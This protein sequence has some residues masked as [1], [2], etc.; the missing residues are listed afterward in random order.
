MSEL[1]N[2][3]IERYEIRERIG[4][5]GMA[6][7]YKAWDTKLERLVAIKLLHEHLA[8]DPAF[9]MRFEREAKVVAS[10]DHPNIVRIFDYNVVDRLG[11]PLCYMVM[12]Y[13]PGKT[14]RQ[15]M[16][17]TLAAGSGLP[18]PRIMRLI[19]HLADALDYA[20]ARGMAHRD[21]KPGNILINEAGAAILTDFGIARLPQST[22]L[23]EEG[24]STGTPAYMSPEQAAGEG[25]DT[26]SDLYSLGVIV[27][28][29]FAGQ[30]PF[31]DENSLSVMMRHISA[32]IPQLSA[33][34]GYSN[35][36][37]DFFIARALAKNPAER[38]QSA[39]AF[40]SAFHRVFRD[41]IPANELFATQDP[42][43]PQQPSPAPV[44][45]APA[46][47][48]TAV[49]PASAAQAARTQHISIIR[50]L[51]A[52]VRA[53]PRASTG[54]VIL[55]AALV[56]TLIISIVLASRAGSSPALTDAQE[57][58]ATR[59]VDGS[60]FRSR[61]DGADASDDLWPILQG[62][63]T[64]DI[65]D[66]IYRV[67]NADPESASSVI[68]GG[69]RYENVIIAL[70]GI[71][72][73][74]SSPDAALGLVFRYQDENNYNVLAVDTQGR[75]GLWRLQDGEWTELRCNCSEL[76]RAWTAS[77][78]IHPQGETN[79]LRVMISGSRLSVYVNQQRLETVEDDTWESGA[80]GIYLGTPEAGPAAAE[81]DVFTLS[82]TVPSMTG[83]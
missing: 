46:V 14:L 59:A 17:E 11:D 9:K 22:R 49:L 40:Q 74:D 32:P 24:A 19:D 52:Q 57:T 5:G 56:L 25:G 16:E 48:T 47:D 33:I 65:A 6:R 82:N 27:F 80:V 21:V 44:A 18:L 28:E 78:A 29:M 75:Y 37:L 69:G 39:R 81:V 31:Q 60:P 15:E 26:R 13:I 20:H 70:E 55:I 67:A 63:F 72:T 71:I 45:S 4:S 83:S 34:T 23:T 53:N 61:F 68:Y 3:R 43:S 30:V 79:A 50:T 2:Q 12:S 35:P 73:A 76:D 66:G 62:S 64:T 54:F 36:K 41:D 38:F 77:D 58:A 51:S 42:L 10:F 7:V 8:D 1:L